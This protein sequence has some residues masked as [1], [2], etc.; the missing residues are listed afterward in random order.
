M[1]LLICGFPHRRRKVTEAV[2][3]VQQDFDF[4]ISGLELRGGHEAARQE[5]QGG[6]MA[7]RTPKVFAA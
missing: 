2:A 4:L 7:A 1:K 6:S 3:A 5:K